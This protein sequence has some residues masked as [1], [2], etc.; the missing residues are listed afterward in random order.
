[1]APF[2]PY[3]RGIEES[4]GK[5]GQQIDE[6]G[7]YSIIRLCNAYAKS[8]DGVENSQGEGPGEGER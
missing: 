4:R 6:G 5:G 7:F 3:K 8:L 1:L 2:I